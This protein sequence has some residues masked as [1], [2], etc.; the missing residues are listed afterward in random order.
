MLDAIE[1]ARLERRLAL[2]FFL[3]FLVLAL[4]GQTLAPG[5]ARRAASHDGL[6]MT[7]VVRTLR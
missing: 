7:T 5:H 2:L 6:A 3:A 4:L 1:R